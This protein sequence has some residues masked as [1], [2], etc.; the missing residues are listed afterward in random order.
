MCEPLSFKESFLQRLTFYQTM[1]LAKEKTPETE[2]VNSLAHLFTGLHT[3]DNNI[4]N[5]LH[6]NGMDFSS[7]NN[8]VN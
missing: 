8:K 7:V 5:I 6:S 1:A 3:A 4:N 2:N